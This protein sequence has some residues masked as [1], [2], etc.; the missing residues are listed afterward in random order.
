MN[1]LQVIIIL[2]KASISFKF[3]FGSGVIVSS[4]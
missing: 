4:V 2:A 3:I 1:D